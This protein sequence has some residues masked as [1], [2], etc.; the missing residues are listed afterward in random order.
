MKEDALS[1]PNSPMETSYSPGINL[2]DAWV[3]GSHIRRSLTD[4]MNKADVQQCDSSCDSTSDLELSSSEAK[5]STVTA[6]P[7]RSRV[8]CIG[9]EACI[10]VSPQSSP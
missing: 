6:T 1:N 9:K 2:S 3:V 5:S 10:S 4:K 7:S 8:W